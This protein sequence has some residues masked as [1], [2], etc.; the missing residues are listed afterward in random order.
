MKCRASKLLEVDSGDGHHNGTPKGH[1][2]CQYFEAID[3][4]VTTIRD[5]YHQPD[6]S[7]YCN[8]EEM[9]TNAANQDDYSKQLEAVTTF[10]VNDLD[11]MPSSVQSQNLSSFLLQ[12]SPE[13]EVSYLEMCTI[14]TLPLVLPATN[15]ASERSF[16]YGA[17]DQDI[18]HQN[19]AEPLI[20]M[21]FYILKS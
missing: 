13:L 18:P 15:T 9:L 5:G 17:Q 4:A 10:Y 1:Y 2:H 11:P 12:L 16:F 14:E 3:L 21:F 6:Y 7:M 8:L 20:L 19:Q